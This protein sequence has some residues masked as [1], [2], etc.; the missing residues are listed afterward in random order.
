MAMSW[1]LVITTL[2]AVLTTLLGV[3]VGG[4]VSN[5]VQTR[6]WLRDH[7]MEAYVQILR[8]SS[9]VWTALASVK[10]QHD[11]APSG[12]G[13]HRLPVNWKP[14]NEF[15]ATVNLTANQEIV[16]AAYVIDERLWRTKLRI[17]AGPIPEEEWFSIRE[18]LESSRREFA[19]V[20]RRHLAALGPLHRIS[21]R[22]GLEQQIIC[23]AIRQGLT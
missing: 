20:A 4:V 7:R 19:N 14:W 1:S 21:G 8:E 3:L 17:K 5:R 22:P 10:A 16:E 18:K 9:N 2:G 12:N 15:L 11:S 6:H 23:Q 13:D